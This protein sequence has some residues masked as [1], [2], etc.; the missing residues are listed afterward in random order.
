MIRSFT[1]WLPSDMWRRFPASFLTVFGANEAGVDLLRPIERG[2]KTA[3]TGCSLLFA[4]SKVFTDGGLL[5]TLAA[6]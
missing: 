4:S 2:K 3:T 1:E 6:S 5:L